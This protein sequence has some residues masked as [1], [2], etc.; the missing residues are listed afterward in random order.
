M[1]GGPVRKKK[2]GFYTGYDF[3]RK[4]TQQDAL[5][6]AMDLGTLTS[7]YNERIKKPPP[8]TP[9]QKKESYISRV[10][11]DTGLSVQQKKER[12]E[13]YGPG[14]EVAK[15]QKEAAAA[16][17]EGPIKKRAKRR[18]QVQDTVLGA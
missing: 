12:M 16:G 9:E 5:N 14:L 15:R 8:Q 4:P 13:D 6:T 7:L 3:T 2:G 11:A 18:R 17:T 10:K 1:G